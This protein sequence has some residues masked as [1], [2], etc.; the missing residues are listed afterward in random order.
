M[1]SISAMPEFLNSDSCA[2][3]E[4]LSP[5]Q[6]SSDPAAELLRCCPLRFSFRAESPVFFPEGKAGN[7]LRGALGTILRRIV[8]VPECPDP[9]RCPEA[10]CA[11]RNVFAPISTGGPSGLADPPR[12]FVLRATHLDGL[13]IAEGNVLSFN[14]HLFSQD[15]EALSLIVLAMRQAFVAGLGPGRPPV[16]LELV[17]QVGAN[18]DP[19]EPLYAAGHMTGAEPKFLAIFDDHRL[20]DCQR[21]SLRFVTPIALK[22]EGRVLRDEAPFPVVWGR[23]RDRV[24]ALRLIY[25]AGPLADEL[26]ASLNKAAAMVR[27]VHKDLRW[28]ETRR[29][30]AR[31]GQEHPLE[32]F[33]GTAT[34]AG[35]LGE[36]VPWLSAGFWSGIGRHCVWGAGVV[37]FEF[38]C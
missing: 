30:S 3:C 36:F 34:Y 17:E 15:P 16:R 21:L 20:A 7:V 10:D 19:I 27:V 18:G 12:P 6:I 14:L 23:L 25:G 2:R 31:T 38:V 28:S 29:R 24:S 13:R 32:G 9:T 11:F 4:L 8:C 33:T 35:P 5:N 1:I 26:I 37:T 22:N